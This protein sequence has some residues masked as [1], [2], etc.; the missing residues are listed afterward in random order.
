MTD[1][2]TAEERSIRMSRIRSRD[3]KPEIVLR[4]TLHR[5]G[6][7]FRLGGADLPGRPD[8]V[9]PKHRAAVFVHGCFWHRHDGCRVA[10]TPKSNAEFWARKFERNV[11]RDQKATGDL[12]A[13]GWKVVVA[14]ECEL[15]SKERLALTTERVKREITA[16]AKAMAVPRPVS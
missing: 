16:Y 11:A 6:L 10:S 7:R 12:K 5:L 1:F 15:G 9:F 2:M 14:W 3:T 13:L 8:M 4:R